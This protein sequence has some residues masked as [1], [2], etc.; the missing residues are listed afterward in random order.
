MDEFGLA[1]T[2]SDHQSHDLE[3]DGLH[4]SLASPVP[5]TP[6][7]ASSFEPSSPKR[8]NLVDMIQEDFPRTPSPVF[9]FRRPKTPTLG[10]GGVDDHE[11]ERRE[12]ADQ[13]RAHVKENGDFIGLSVNTSLNGS[14][15]DEQ[16]RIASVLSSALEEKEYFNPLPQR[17]AS[18][19]PAHN[20]Y[21]G[22][23]R[24]GSVPPERL[25]MNVMGNMA[26]LPQNSAGI[27]PEL[28]MAMG[29]L[30]VE[31]CMNDA[32]LKSTYPL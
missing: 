29:T 12:L 14:G 3:Y 23:N 15:Y 7:S 28:L 8:K 6:L 31:V 25:L 2:N 26:G 19:P 22:V 9:A 11:T 30:G 21:Q 4:G 20:P 13:I 1:S 32:E 16:S 5:M 27:P 10:S 24:P 18:T 17:P